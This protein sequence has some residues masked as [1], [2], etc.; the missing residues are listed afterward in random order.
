MTTIDE[1]LICPNIQQK[2][3]IT[4]QLS[5]NFNINES[6]F[7]ILMSFLSLVSVMKKL[8]WWHEWISSDQ[9]FL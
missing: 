2:N 1:K 6:L 5:K 9:T 7:S 4:L 3:F 8:L